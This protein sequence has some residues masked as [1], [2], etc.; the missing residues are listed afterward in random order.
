MGK[1]L[2]H[3]ETHQ[4]LFQRPVPRGESYISNIREIL[5][6][7]TRQR[8]DHIRPY[9]ETE[10]VH[11]HNCQNY[12]W[13]DICPPPHT[14]EYGVVET[15]DESTGVPR[16]KRQHLLYCL[17]IRVAVVEEEAQV[18]DPTEED[19]VEEE[20][21]RRKHGKVRPEVAPSMPRQRQRV[22][23]AALRCGQPWPASASLGPSGW[24]AVPGGALDLEAHAQLGWAEGDVD[25]RG[26]DE[27]GPGEG[28]G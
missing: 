28:E 15:T 24:P 7:I 8:R 19:A 11:T 27:D 25:G 18:D 10:N 23:G 21:L 1:S 16:R 2:Q 13:R 17:A 14:R 20:H 26:G 22:P 12:F 4:R 5:R 6:E 9:D 3:S